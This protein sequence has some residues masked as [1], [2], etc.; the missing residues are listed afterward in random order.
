MNEA[1]IQQTNKFTAENQRKLYPKLIKTLQW[2]YN[3]RKPV[4]FSEA[5]ENVQSQKL[6]RGAML[7]G[8]G[9]ISGP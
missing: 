3:H 9:L 2:K 7:S 1:V 5:T 6:L 8:N 4:K